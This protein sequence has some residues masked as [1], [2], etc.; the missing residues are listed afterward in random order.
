M[1]WVRRDRS[2]VL[3]DVASQVPGLSWSAG[4]NDS[5]LLMCLAVVV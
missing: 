1:P 4:A 3:G 2:A 5:L